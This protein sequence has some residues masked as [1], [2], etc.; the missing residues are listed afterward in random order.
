MSRLTSLLFINPTF[1]ISTPRPIVPVSCL[2]AKIL[3][4]G[5]NTR[6]SHLSRSASP[7]GHPRLRLTQGQDLNTETRPRITQR[8]PTAWLCIGYQHLDPRLGTIEIGYIQI[9]KPR[10]HVGMSEDAEFV[11]GTSGRL[12]NIRER[13]G[14]SLGCLRTTHSVYSSIIAS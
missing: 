9:H 2:T 14:R 3:R 13:Q 10:C 11:R 4:K 8:A 7:V 5:P 6:H 1:L 12:E